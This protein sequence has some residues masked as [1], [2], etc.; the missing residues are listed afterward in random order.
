VT[1][2]VVGVLLG[3]G[4]GAVRAG[5]GAAMF[6]VCLADLVRWGARPRAGGSRPVQ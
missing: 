2:W 6:A 5:A 3:G 1:A 4:G